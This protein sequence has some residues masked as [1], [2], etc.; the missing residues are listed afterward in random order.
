MRT[1]TYCSPTPDAKPRVCIRKN[2]DSKNIADTGGTAPGACSEI[3]R[4]GAPSGQT[5]STETGT[6]PTAILFHCHYTLEPGC[7]KRSEIARCAR[8]FPPVV[9][10]GRFVCTSNTKCPSKHFSSLH[11]AISSSTYVRRSP[12][13]LLHALPAD[14]ARAM[15]DEP[16]VHARL[17]EGVRAAGQPPRCLTGHNVLRQDEGR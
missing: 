5:N 11:P 14:G 17:V 2:E 16:S 9:K 12:I 3:T 13:Y 7:K 4:I 15:A 1:E 8:P 10:T 6:A